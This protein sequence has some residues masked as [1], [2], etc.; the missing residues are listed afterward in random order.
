MDAFCMILG[1]TAFF[2]LIL[3]LTQVTYGSDGMRIFPGR[4][5]DR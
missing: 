5:E 2:L 3:I 4:W 1:V